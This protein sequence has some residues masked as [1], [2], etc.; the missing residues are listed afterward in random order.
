[1]LARDSGREAVNPNN[2]D[3]MDIIMHLVSL[4]MI[5]MLLEPDPIAR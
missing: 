1:L 2:K 4:F 5:Y 3:L